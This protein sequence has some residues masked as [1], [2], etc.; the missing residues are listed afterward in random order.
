MSICLHLCLCTVSLERAIASWLSRIFL[1]G[2]F[3]RG[4]IS[5]NSW[6]RYVWPLPGPCAKP[7]VDN[8]TV[9]C[10]FYFQWCTF[11]GVRGFRIDSWYITRCFVAVI[12]VVV[13][14]TQYFMQRGGYRTILDNC[15]SYSSCPSGSLNCSVFCVR[16]FQILCLVYVCVGFYFL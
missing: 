2:C 4:S 13:A 10:F 7:H 15:P 8:A 6:M 9:S 1:P 14:M 12:D 11:G 3:C 16:V 5:F